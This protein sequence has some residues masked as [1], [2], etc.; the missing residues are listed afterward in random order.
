MS[1]KLTIISGKLKGQVYEL[2]AEA[3]S[4]GRE[5]SNRIFLKDASVSRQHCLIEKRDGGFFITDLKSLNGTFVNGNRAENT[6]LSHGDRIRIGDFTLRFQTGDLVESSSEVFFDQT[7]FHFPENS[8]QLRLEE[9]FGAMA[10]DLTA[11]LRI[12]SK[13]NT[14]RQPEEIE[15]ELL[16]LVFE[17]IP[18]DSGA[19]LLVDDENQ[20]IEVTGRNRFDESQTVHVSQT[21]VNQVLKNQEVILIGDLAAGRDLQEAESLFLMKISTLICVPVVLFEKTTG[22]IY[23]SASG[24]NFDEGHLRFLTA[25]AGIAAAAIENAR[26]FARLESE[27]E[28]LRGES[29]ERNMIGGSEAMTKVFGLIERVAPAD[30]TVLITGESGTGKELAAQSIHLNSR[31]RNGPFV[32]INCAAL[33]E[34]LLESELFGHEK[35]SFTG[36]VQQKKGKIEM[37]EGGTLFLDEIGEMATNLQ[38][39]LLRVL[40]EREFERVGGTRPVKADIRLVAATNRDLLEEI[41]KG[42]FREDLFY[43]LNVVQIKMPALRERRED[44]PPLAEY[45]TEKLGR[46]PNRRIRGISARAQKLLLKYDFPGNVRE[47]ENAIERAVVLGST[48]W[49]LP[50]D[51]P[52]VFSDLSI[53]TGEADTFQDAVREKKKELIREAFQ[54]AEGSYVETA[55]L[56]DL[57]PNYLHRLIRNLEMKDELE[58]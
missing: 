27:N 54:K 34:T 53:E 36:A 26:N 9:V 48:E 6:A 44:I 46:K 19:I 21:I 23:L 15:E 17:V 52:E 20:P 58:K 29:F 56:L 2:D 55:R 25:V 39:K 43:R 31:R 3:V 45:F 49:I 33:T 35:G 13:I 14:I 11:I 40:Q 28:R 8:R 51:L 4:I 24:A 7:E 42:A 30:S 32:A 41:K 37:A 47:L 18:A 50:E 22:A 5:S 57:H 38:T 12:S 10:R 16:R 1:E